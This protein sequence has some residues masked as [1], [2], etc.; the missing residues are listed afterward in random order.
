MPQLQVMRGKL[1]FASENPRSSLETLQLFCQIFS[2]FV[3]ASFH[4]R[5]EEVQ[6]RIQH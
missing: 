6:D 5:W 4:L 1:T 3:I 2:D